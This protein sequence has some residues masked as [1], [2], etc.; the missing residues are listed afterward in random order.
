M[1]YLAIDN[2]LFEHSGSYFDDN[3]DPMLIVFSLDFKRG[4]KS[5]VKELKHLLTGVGYKQIKIENDPKENVIWLVVKGS[6][7]TFDEKMREATEI[8]EDPINITE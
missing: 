7:R 3:E 1:D 2:F 6:Y 8:T 5:R 4:V